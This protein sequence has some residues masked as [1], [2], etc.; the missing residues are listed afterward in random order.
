MTLHSLL[1]ILQRLFICI[2]PGVTALQ[3]RAICVIYV[4]VRLY[5]HTK[6][7]RFLW[8]SKHSCALHSKYNNTATAAV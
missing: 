3:C 2:A 1:N 6:D 7:I 8:P 4:F 5:D